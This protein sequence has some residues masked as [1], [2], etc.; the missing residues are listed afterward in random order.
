MSQ[1]SETTFSA[2][3]GAQ[4]TI[5][6]SEDGP[7]IELSINE[8]SIIER[9]RQDLNF[10]NSFPVVVMGDEKRAPLTNQQVNRALRVHLQYMLDTDLLHFM[11]VMAAAFN[12]WSG[13]ITSGV[14]DLLEGLGFDRE[15]T[16]HFRAAARPFEQKM[17][18][19]YS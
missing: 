8:P 5:T 3:C 13:V 14:T 4:L 17:E 19:Q 7:T 1:G 10:R 18:E 2:E 6:T 12:R 9:R 16:D 11:A 15:V